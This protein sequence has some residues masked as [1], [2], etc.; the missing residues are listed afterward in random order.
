MQLAHPNIRFVFYTLL[1]FFLLAITGVIRAQPLQIGSEKAGIDTVSAAAILLS[2][3]VGIPS[4]TGNEKKAADFLM[5]QCGER[6][7]IIN[8]FTD[9]IGSSNFSAS[10]YPLHLGKPNIIFL[11]HI[12]V[13]PAGDLADWIF[14]P[15]E[16]RIDDGKVWGRGSFDNKGL[17]IV[18]LSAIERFLDMAHT[19][20]LPYNV[21]LLSVSGEET[22]GTNGSAIVSK[23]FKEVFAPAVVIGEGGSGINEMDFLPEGKTFF[24]ISIA[25]KGILWLKISCMIKGDGHASIAGNDYANKHLIKGLNRLVKTHQPIRMTDEAQ[26]MFRSIGKKVGGLK[27]FAVTHLNWLVFR[28]FLNKI[29]DQNHELESLLC[30]AI[31][32]SNMGNL[33]GSPNQNKQEAMAFIDCR[34]LPGVSSN[35][36][37]EFISKKINDPL[38]HI[39]ILHQRPKQ[40]GTNPEFFFNQLAKSIQVVYEGAEVVPILFPASNDNFYFRSDEC[41][42]Y[43]LNPMITS[44]LQ[45]QSI[46]N[47]NEFIDLEDIDKGIE[48]FENFLRSV[49][50]SPDSILSGSEHQQ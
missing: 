4:E 39:S 5:Q 32:V 3:Y 11:N 9:K 14:P 24:G 15:Y 45:I 36:M 1:S 44:K 2:T 21:T 50:F 49:L 25:E 27:G 13:V 17:A 29:I 33:T 46:H 38:L 30:N 43:G 28:P 31:T 22:G 20:D 16:G 47:Y 10:L 42:V 48:V 41:P 37:I 18:Q 26:L 19:H 23:N 40:S 35:E 7:L 8:Q 12:D 6:G 34:L